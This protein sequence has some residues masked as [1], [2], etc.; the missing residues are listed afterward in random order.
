MDEDFYPVKENLVKGASTAEDA[1]FLVDLGGGKGHDLEELK[2][3]HLNL[4]GRLVLQDLAS[5]LAEAKEL[6]PGI[7]K[8]EHDFFTPQPVQGNCPLEGKLGFH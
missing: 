5:V 8:M 2:R 6:D 7:M 3:K 1:V 4:P